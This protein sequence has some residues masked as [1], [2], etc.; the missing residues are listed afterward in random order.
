M[1]SRASASSRQMRVG[2]LASGRGSNLGAVLAAVADGR[3]AGIEPRLV[4]SNRAGVS[5]LDVAAAHGVPTLVL[6]RGSFETRAAR[7]AAIGRALSEAGVELALLA[8]YDELL[9]PPYFR[10]FAGRTIN[11]HPSLLPAHGGRGMIG[12]AVHAAV[13]AAGDDE[14]GVSIHEVTDQLDAGPVLAQRRVRVVP[15]ESR[16]ALADRVL[17]HEHELL[18]ETL[19]HLGPA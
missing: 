7:D 15:G 1:E 5:A 19:A 3:L 18:V 2:V 6:E 16:E 10:E 17:R 13:L 4:I 8:G 11:I 9:R 14:T 12:L